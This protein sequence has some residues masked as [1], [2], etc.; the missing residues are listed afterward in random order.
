MTEPVPSASESGRLRC[1]FFT[2]PAVKVTLFHAS[3]ENSEPT[4]ATATTV[5]IPT[6]AMGPPTPTCTG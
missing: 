3:A 5:N 1:G 4:W 6:S 2:S